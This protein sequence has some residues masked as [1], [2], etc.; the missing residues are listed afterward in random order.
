MMDEKVKNEL[1]KLYST[2]GGELEFDYSLKAHSTIAIGG[3]ASVWL[4]PSSIEE[5]KEA[6]SFLEDAGVEVFIIG[7]GSNILIPDKHLNTAFIKLGLGIFKEITF[8]HQ[9][10]T[11]GSGVLLSRLLS[12]CC[13]KGL[14][15]MEGLVGI[16][17][18]LGGAL[19]MNASYESAISDPLSKVLVLDDEGRMEW[20]D[21]GDIKFGYRS[22][23][24][25]EDA[26]ILQ[27]VFQ[28]EEDSPGEIVERLKS[29]FVD[30]IK[31]QPF[32]KRSLG[33]V[34]KNPAEHEYTSAE[35]IDSCGMKGYTLGDAEISLEHANFIIN[36][37]EAS[38]ED[39]V[40]LVSEVQKKVREKFSV[41]LEPEI[42]I[43]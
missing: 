25:K 35:M 8:D 19:V 17:G 10:V 42:K 12:S 15:G 5:L 24:F 7:A 37:G 27:A 26:V 16:P 14:K 36:R 39:V 3:E 34:F 6:K 22:S 29:S 21:K 30:K 2:W 23:S 40:S 38:Y 43:L 41:E 33:C 13:R 32:G 31:K 18:T 9:T 28:L 20:L 11:V 4:V 1:R